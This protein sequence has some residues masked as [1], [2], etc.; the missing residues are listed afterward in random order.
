[1]ATGQLAELTGLNQPTV[2]KVSKTLMTANLLE[3]QRGVHGGYKLA[4]PVSA[5]SLVQIVEAMEGPIAVSDCICTDGTYD[6]CMVSNSCFV[7]RSWDQ[8]NLAI[9]NALN[10]VSLE[11]LI[12]TSQLFDS[13]ERQSKPN[14]ISSAAV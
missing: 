7:T 6:R 2:A 4:R 14:Q 5:M 11:D 13:W 1:M 9:R 10:E 3:T 12:D 8:V